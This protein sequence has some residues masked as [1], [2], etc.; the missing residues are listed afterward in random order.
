MIRLLNLCVI[1]ALVFAA[2]HV[3]RIKF[4]STR[5][6]ERV[7]KLRLE[8]RREHDVIAMLRAE[9]SKLDNPVRIQELAKRHLKNLQLVDGRQFDRL[10][11]LP[12]RPP[13]LVPPDADDPIGALLEK[14]EFTDPPTTASVSTPSTKR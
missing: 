1:A 13:A 4:E 11:R 2:A 9:W 6:A 14:P 3:Y 10:D 7:A 12:M 5:Q 8:I